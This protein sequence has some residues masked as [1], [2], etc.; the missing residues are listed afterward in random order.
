[1]ASDGEL[2]LEMLDRWSW[3]KGLVEK[4][5]IVCCQCATEYVIGTFDNVEY[6]ECWRCLYEGDRYGKDRTGQLQYH[7]GCWIGTKPED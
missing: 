1:M 4:Q 6:E 7:N 3:H 5:V 2:A